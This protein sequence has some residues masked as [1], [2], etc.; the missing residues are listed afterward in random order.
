MPNIITEQQEQELYSNAYKLGH[1]FVKS[2]RYDGNDF[3]AGFLVGILEEKYLNLG[4]TLDKIRVPLRVGNRKDFKVTKDGPV[5]AKNYKQYTPEEKQGFSKKQSVSIISIDKKYYP[6]VFGHNRDRR[7]ELVGVMFFSDKIEKDSHVLPSIIMSYD[8]GTVSRSYDFDSLEMAQQYFDDKKQDVWH[9]RVESLI[10]VEMKHNA[11][12]YNEVLA[13]IRWL[14]N[15]D[16]CQVGVFADNLKSRLIAQMRAAD[17]KNNTEQ[18]FIPISFYISAKESEEKVYPYY[19]ED[20][21]KDLER[22]LIDMS[23]PIEEKIIA[24]YIYF[25]SNPKNNQQAYDYLINMLNDGWFREDFCQ[26]LFFMNEKITECSRKI[27]L[28]NIINI[29]ETKHQNLN[30]INNLQLKKILLMAAICLEDISKVDGLSDF[31]DVD[32]STALYFAAVLGKKEVV[33]YL[34]RKPGI[35]YNAVNDNDET[36]FFGAVLSGNK[37]IV[38]FLLK[39]SDIDW[40]KSEKNSRATPL[41]EAIKRN[42]KGIVEL[43]LSNKNIDCNKANYKGKTPLHIAVSD[44]NVEIIEMLLA[45]DNIRVNEVD[46][47]GETPLVQAIKARNKE[48]VKLL[49][50]N[51][52]KIDCNKANKE[53]ETPLHIAISYDNEEIVEML[54]KRDDILVNKANNDKNTPLHIAI[55]YD[56]EEIVEMLLAHD[57]IWVNEVDSYGETPLVKAVRTGNE[58]IVN[59]LLDSGKK[60]DYN[61][62]NNYNETPLHIAVSNG[63]VEIIKML[64]KCDNIRVN[65]VDSYGDT[66]L[67]KAIN[68]KNA[69]IVE[70]LLKKIP[71]IYCNKANKDGETPLHRAVAVGNE[72]IVTLL[73]NHDGI[74][75]NEV[76]SYGDTPLIKAIKFIKAINASKAVIA[77]LLLN[78]IKKI[79]CNKANKKGE[80]P[81]HRAVDAGDEAVVK[82]LLERDNILVNE[83][84]SYGDTP[85]A[86]AIDGGNVAIVKLLL[87]KEKTVRAN[88]SQSLDLKSLIDTAAA[89]WVLKNKPEQLKEMLDLLNEYKNQ[90]NDNIQQP[91]TPTL[92]LRM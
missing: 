77:K 52:K 15:D 43:L 80:T 79:D 13:R 38:D 6:P 57:N 75:C 31:I 74:L 46:S 48:I 86:K 82:L 49:L 87:E 10:N 23:V 20:Q 7:E 27:I 47:Y 36:I 65:E 91:K 83:I 42:N 90:E 19:L 54:L 9:D 30:D 41:L 85:L 89:S 70:L 66:L 73:L 60:I 3:W 64:L 5:E 21:R 16:R 78:N 29:I 18:E 50:N 81:L 59:Q 44:G 71:I 25:L 1:V 26:L 11:V 40:N 28:N 45:H 39:K 51:S 92:K 61:K 37:E 33:N 2:I 88:N 84:D 4:M 53:G 14:I 32:N 62:A 63:N 56:N 68:S 22:A 76:D 17:I 67:M 24:L 69:A 72:E 55:S 8:G 12:Y 35:N 58:V 34:L